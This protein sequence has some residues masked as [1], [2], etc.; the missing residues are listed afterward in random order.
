MSRTTKYDFVE[1][2]KEEVRE[3]ERFQCDCCG[4]AVEG[5]DV[6]PKLKGW[7]TLD[8]LVRA[9]MRTPQCQHF[10]ERC[11]KAF[12]EFYY[13]LKNYR[14]VRFTASPVRPQLLP[15]YLRLVQGED[16][17]PQTAQDSQSQSHAP[18]PEQP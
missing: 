9:N 12:N 17:S 8:T 18:N 7:S 10:C 11:T 15:P 3:I 1:V 2:K 5:V 16:E 14:G 13:R 4:K 6:D